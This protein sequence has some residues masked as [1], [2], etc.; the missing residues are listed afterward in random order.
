MTFKVMTWNLENLFRSGSEYGPK[1]KAPF[2]SSA[3]LS[4]RIRLDLG[5]VG[6][7]RSAPDF[8]LGVP[9]LAERRKWR[10]W[11]GG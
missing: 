9:P 8:N 4:H 5:L 2:T 6:G 3:R 10:V 11:L 7:T 1:T